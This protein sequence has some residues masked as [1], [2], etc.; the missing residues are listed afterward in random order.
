MNRL[1]QS[2]RTGGIELPASGAR[3]VYAIGDFSPVPETSLEDKTRLCRVPDDSFDFLGYTFGRCYSPKT[4]RAY[5]GS[6]PSKKSIKRLIESIGELTER[7]H[8]H[9]EAAD[10]VRALNRKLTGWANCCLGPVSKA[11]CAIDA[12]TS[13]RLRQWLC[14]KHRHRGRGYQRYPAHYL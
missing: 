9:H 11:Y 6:N 4:G 14:G 1:L 12:Y 5:I 10:L 13:R 3:K 7:K 2:S 8:F